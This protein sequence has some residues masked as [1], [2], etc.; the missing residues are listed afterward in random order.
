ML[1]KFE[2]VAESLRPKPKGP[3]AKAEAEATLVSKL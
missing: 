2:A 1:L 3:E